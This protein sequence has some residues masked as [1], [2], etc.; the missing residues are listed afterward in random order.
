[1][2]SVSVC[3]LQLWLL[4]NCVT[5]ESFELLCNLLSELENYMQLIFA[6]THISYRRLLSE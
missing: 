1:M 3:V 4:N 5:I 2:L 6:I